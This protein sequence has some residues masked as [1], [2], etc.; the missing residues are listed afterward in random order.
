MIKKHVII[1]VVVILVLIGYF[2]YSNYTINNVSSPYLSQVPSAM[3]NK[4]NTLQIPISIKS[5]LNTAMVGVSVQAFTN[6]GSVSGCTTDNNGNCNVV[7]S[8][9]VTSSALHAAINVNAEGLTQSISV[10]VDPDPTDK[11]SL[12]SQS[13]SLLADGSSSTIIT[14]TAYDSTG[15]TVPDGTPISFTLSSQGAGGTISANSC[16]TVNGNCQITYTASTTPGIT[17]IQVSSYNA[18]DSLQ[19]T[20]KP[21]YNLIVSF[22]PTPQI[23]NPVVPAFAL[24]YQYLGNSMTTIF[25]SN[26]GFGTFTGTVQL[27]IPG[28]SNAVSQNINLGPGGETTVN[29]NPD[30]NSQALSNLQEQS[31]NY[32]LTI[33][34]SNGQTVYQN[35][36]A[37][38]ITSFNTMNWGTW[39]NNIIAA[40]VQPNAPGIHQLLSQAADG[41]PGRSMVGYSGTYPSGC[42]VL[43]LSA[44]DQADSTYLQLQAIY[45]Q[46][47]KNGMHYVNAPQDFSGAQ[48]VY[49]PSQSLQDGG[50][51]C[52]D[53]TLVFA[54]AVSATSMQPYVILVPSHAFVCVSTYS[55]SHVIDCVETTMIGGGSTFDQAY[56]EGNSEY[57]QYKSQG[58][59]SLVDV[60]SVLSS[61]VKSL[62]P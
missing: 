17:T 5:K 37:T 21:V 39:S 54:S 56:T 62:P 32:Q 53:G 10:N 55:N 30:L 46:L 19:I 6:M 42:G 3:G 43:G 38:S 4:Q 36:Y 59:L 29:L 40:W 28:W 9:P 7:F 20:L 48:T 11:L 27:S 51:N 52:I 44:C 34:N 31:A 50:A 57:S 45:N 2:I 25:I 35:T 12:E 22:Y 13:S 49:T 15:A 41:L 47:Q 24:N 18:V 8:P 23:G 26:S 60:N 1:I 61:G 14:I 58:Q 16:T 33:Q